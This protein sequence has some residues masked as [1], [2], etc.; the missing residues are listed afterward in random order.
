MSKEQLI[1]K[2]N[3]LK[4]DR[5]QR[6]NEQIEHLQQTIRRRFDEM[7]QMFQQPLIQEIL[8]LRPDINLEQQQKELEEAIQEE[9]DKLIEFIRE[10]EN[11]N[12]S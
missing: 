6:L 11:N 7:E 5:N 1:E 10:F 9:I 12:N 3:Q 4:K 8:N 2:L